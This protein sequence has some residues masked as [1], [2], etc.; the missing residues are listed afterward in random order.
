MAVSSEEIRNY[1]VLVG[2]LITIGAA[3]LKAL[4]WLFTNKEEIRLLKE[5]FKGIG[6]KLDA[7]LHRLEIGDTRIH[8]LEQSSGQVRA[9]VAELSGRCGANHANRQR[10]T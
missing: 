5:Q 1:G 4:Q 8:E 9:D 10:G 3:C 6:E 7:I 2:V